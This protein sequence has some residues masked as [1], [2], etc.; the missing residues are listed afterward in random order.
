MFQLLHWNGSLAAM[1]ERQCSRQVSCDWWR[2]GHVTTV[3]TS[4][5]LTGGGAA[6]QPPRAGRRH[7][8]ADGAG[9]DRTG[10]GEL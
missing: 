3:L 6:L 9:L 10:A 2:A 5:W 4:D 1:R 7:A 8:L